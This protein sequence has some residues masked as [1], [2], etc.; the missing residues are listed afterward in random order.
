VSRFLFVVPPL[1]G[2]VNPTISVGR[3]LLARGHEVA[4]CGEPGF[5]A[6][7]LPEGAA[8]LPSPDG[9]PADVTEAIEERST[10]LRGAAALKFLWEDVLH[11]LAVAMVPGVEAAVDRFEP[12][13]VVADQQAFAGALVARRRG[14]PWATSATTSAEL[15]RPLEGLPKIAAWVRETL[16]DF[17][18]E[19]G[20]PRAEAEAG[21]LRFSE[22]LV[23]AFTTEAF[24]GS[25]ETFPPAV[26]CVGPST[27][28]RPERDDFPWDRLDADRPT[29]LVSLGT[30]N[31]A[32]GE[33]FFAAAAE[34]LLELGVQGVLVA[35]PELL[36]LADLDAGP[37][38]LIVQPW[39]PQL[40][41]LDEVDAVVTHAGHNTTCE[42]LAHGL[43]LVVAPIRDDQ[44]VVA[45]QVV[46]AGAGVRVRFGRVRPAEL[47]E[48]VR[49]VLDDPT[50]REA[51][52][53]LQ[54]SFHEAGGS[55]RA[56]DELEKLA[57]AA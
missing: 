25:P 31:Q 55:A 18:V 20:V 7:R 32:A 46:A 26:V 34:A 23:L 11:P 50:Y 36:P 38:D 29:V 54:Q 5:L 43:P 41:L 35:P 3:E 8:V 49:A 10:G 1:T 51:A 27:D 4:W 57:V 40:A 44:P 48:A 15:A 53:R 45:D 42:A 52:V 21:D 17:Q 47:A 14:L 19:C 37:D 13:V 28:D 24:V 30:V 39:V 22:H 56:A 2:H 16:V 12:D 33:R 6:G 9:L